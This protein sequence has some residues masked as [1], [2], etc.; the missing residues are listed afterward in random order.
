MAMWQNGSKWA[1]VLMLASAVALSGCGKDKPSPYHSGNY[2]GKLKIGKPYSIDGQMYYPSVDVNYDEEGVA[3]WYGPGFHG[4]ST[5]NGERFDQNAMTAA[6]RTL[7]LPSKVRVTNLENGKTAILKVNDRGP[8]KNNRIIDLSKAAAQELGVIA[9]GTARVRVQYL[10]HE[11]KQMIAELVEDNELVADD[12]SLLALG[13]GAGTPDVVL[14]QSATDQP[15]SRGFGLVSGAA[16]AE[17]TG[18]ANPMPSRG[19][20]QVAPVRPVVSRSLDAPAGAASVAAT[21]TGMVGATMPDN[22]RRLVAGQELSAEAG[23]IVSPPEMQTAQQR[24]AMMHQDSAPVAPTPQAMRQKSMAPMPRELSSETLGRATP[25]ALPGSNPLA[26]QPEPVRT[27]AV[28]VAPRPAIAARPQQAPTSASPSG[29]YVQAGSFSQADNA[30][31]FAER[32]NSVGTAGVKAVQVNGRTWYRVRVGPVSD[33]SSA[34][35]L[36]QKVVNLGHGDARI[37]RD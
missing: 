36:L 10:P 24:R 33:H 5:A 35:S 17:P 37:V 20:D 32:L 13:I 4:R 11:T 1:C 19:I 9:K 29:L 21:S 27:A 22:G 26:I 18:T 25:P 8:F 23:S 7:P 14:A 15:R 12:E 6:H 16:A 2:P 31:D 30:Y 28:A 34:N 3:S